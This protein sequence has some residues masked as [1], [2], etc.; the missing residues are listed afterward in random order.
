MKKHS[1]W[2]FGPAAIAVA[3]GVLVPPG[4]SQAKDEWD[5][6]AY[7]TCIKAA[8]DRLNADKISPSQYYDELRFCC[9]MS[10]GQWAGGNGNHSAGK[11]EAP[12][13]TAQTAPKS[14]GEVV[15]APTAGTADPGQNP[16]RTGGGTFEVVPIGPGGPVLY[17]P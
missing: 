17:N 11:C 2:V 16:E 8:Q 6:G 14:P 12:P 9:D 13:A 4:V 7:D 15:Q 3:I 5:I 1:L 10:G